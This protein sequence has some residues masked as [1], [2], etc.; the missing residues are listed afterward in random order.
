MN[1][2][3][4]VIRRR[5]ELGISQKQLAESVDVAPAT[6]RSLEQNR[7]WPLDT[8]RSAIEFQ[9]GWDYGSLDAIRDGGVPT[10]IP[11]SRLRHPMNRSSLAAQK[12]A[13]DEGL[14]QF[15]FDDADETSDDASQGIGDPAPA[16]PNLDDVV[17]LNQVRSSVRILDQLPAPVQAVVLAQAREY[18]DTVVDFLDEERVQELVIEAY[19]LLDEQLH[20]ADPGTVASLDERRSNTPDDDVEPLGYVADSSPD[21]PEMGD[22][23]YHDGP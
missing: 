18:L 11:L 15:P 23:D 20:D 8:T 3:E 9:L 13:A 6:V 17:A 12:L 2:G 5:A 14:S 1:V 19:R 22:D 21:E 10:L 7:R 16:L 4:W